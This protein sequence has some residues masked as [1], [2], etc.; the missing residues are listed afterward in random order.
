MVAS[1][2]YA[3]APPPERE[4]EDRVL[5]VPS[6]FGTRLREQVKSASE[7]TANLFMAADDKVVGVLL[8]VP[9]YE[10]LKAAARLA[11]DPSR[12]NWLLQHQG[13]NHTRT[14]DQVFPQGCA[15]DAAR[16]ASD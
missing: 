14:L 13:S 3:K 6:D 7:S 16:Y 12:L 4:D 1:A 11:H 15:V 5:V 10:L 9:A 8:S 2:A